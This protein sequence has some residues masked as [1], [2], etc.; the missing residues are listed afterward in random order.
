MHP[1]N[2]LINKDEAA[3][4][5][6]R[7]WWFGPTITADEIDRELE[8]MKDAGIG[9]VEIAFLYPVTTH[10]DEDEFPT[11]EFLSPEFIRVLQHAA[12]SAEELGLILDVT[13]GSGWPYGGPHI[14][15]DLCAKK[16]KIE[17]V[18]VEAGAIEYTLASLAEND[19]II[20][21]TSNDLSIKVIGAKL[22]FED[23]LKEGTRVCVLISKPTGQAVKRAAIGA[24]GPAL[25]H[26]SKD[27]LSAHLSAVGLPMLE[28]ASNGIRAIFCDSLEVY[29]AS[30]TPDFLN[31]FKKLRGYD[32]SDYFPK[33]LGAMETDDDGLLHLSDNLK[34]ADAVHDLLHDYAQTLQEL[35]EQRFLKPLQAYC[36]H[37]EVACR[38]QVYGV[39][40]TSLSS[41]Q[42]VDIPEGETTLG[43]SELC[44]P[45]DW[46][47]LT[48][49]RFAAS[50]G[51]HY[52]KKIIS[53]ETWTRLHSP[54][55]AATLLDMK[56]EADQFLL[57]G[58]NQ[59]IGHGWCQRPANGDPSQWL[60]YAAANFNEANPWHPAL[61]E[62]TQYLERICSIMRRGEPVADVAIYLPDHDM[63]S[64]RTFSESKANLHHVNSLRDYI[65]TELPKSLLA[66]GYNFDLI[67]DQ[68]LQETSENKGLNNKIIILPRITRIPLQSL[69]ALQQ[70]AAAGVWIVALD[71]VPTRAPGYLQHQ[72]DSEAV[73]KLSNELFHSEK[74][75]NVV[76]QPSFDP[77]QFTSK[78]KPDVELQQPTPQVGYVHR[79]HEGAD[80]Y[81]FSNTSNQAITLSPKFRDSCGT[82]YQ[83]NPMS[84]ETIKIN[85]DKIELQAFESV[86]VVR[87]AENTTI[88]A[89]Q[90]NQMLPSTGSLAEEIF[91]N[92]PWTLSIPAN[93]SS[94]TLKKLQP[95]TD[96]SEYHSFS[97]EA[98]Y[99]SFFDIKGTI[100][101]ETTALLSFDDSIAQT[102]Y[103]ERAER[104]N[105]GF[106]VFL[107]SPIM[108]AAIVFING[109]K[110]GTLFSPPYR[111][112]IS[113]AIIAGE[114]RLEIKV[115]NRLV[116]QL[117]HQALYDFT[118]V[119]AQYGARFNG[120]Q[121]IEDFRSETSGLKGDV[122]IQVY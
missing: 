98:I 53:G 107:D 108:D 19:K 1:F 42:Y 97:G 106:S 95:W 111:V 35:L 84:G 115:Y 78:V 20:A 63:M 99:S 44:L 29:N 67:D 80:L 40:P 24:E 52:G 8:L 48:P 10:S 66:M 110:V 105:T 94:R 100:E 72:T 25:D 87:L 45:A 122:K 104:R 55:Y 102:P 18:L 36:A 16:L 59:I 93:G 34:E 83:V 5:M 75:P 3:R 74:Y 51:K 70:H 9:G 103:R 22:I 15:P 27:A 39:P 17:N 113:Q 65:G 112:N 60:F 28:A 61:P 109:K 14:T 21:A 4:I 2:D 38:V 26:Y 118:E 58:I 85:S 6:M 32:L 13:M 101:P 7:W 77:S 120:I 73:A 82:N 79:K 121:D 86:L 71:G 91:L 119:H 116:N 30:W 92:Q 37:Y 68:I 69:E 57:Q 41:Y 81:F 117:S 54:P 62:L 49:L 76:S 47:E 64:K 88:A 114:N 23:A 12:K 50:A 89:P 33:L 90:A 43:S 31:E 56:A 96:F 11:F 46:T